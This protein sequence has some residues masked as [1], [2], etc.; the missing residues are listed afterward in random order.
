[1]NY[2][3]FCPSHFEDGRRP[4]FYSKLN[5]SRSEHKDWWFWYVLLKCHFRYLDHIYW[6]ICPPKCYLLRFESNKRK[7]TIKW[8]LVMN[9]Y[10]VDIQNYCYCWIHE[11]WKKT[12]TSYIPPCH[13]TTL[14]TRQ[15]IVCNT[16][17]SND[18]DDKNACC[19]N[20]GLK[21]G[22]SI[23][24][25]AHGTLPWALVLFYWIQGQKINVYHPR[26]HLACAQNITSCIMRYYG[27]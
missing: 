18:A 10:F 9:R 1:M 5:M 11:C 25:S 8:R 20:I 19:C 7:A 12:Q 3:A 27:V 16:M 6:H 17:L 4:I 22:K 13:I 24:L 14:T 15:P 26:G 21:I 2:K 23:P